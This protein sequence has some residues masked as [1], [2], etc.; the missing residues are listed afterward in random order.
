MM[1]Q[2]MRPT[3]EQTMLFDA[4]DEEMKQCS[5]LSTAE[6]SM[7]VS[8]FVMKF[9]FSNS[10]AQHKSAKG[11]ADMLLYSLNAPE[12]NVPIINK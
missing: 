4:I 7:I 8:D 5:S 11:W 3:K 2:V 10:A 12:F 1:S 9:D 6:R